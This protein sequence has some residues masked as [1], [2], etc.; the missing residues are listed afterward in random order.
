MLT[1]F[2]DGVQPFL[3]LEPAVELDEELEILVHRADQLL[4]MGCET[5]RKVTYFVFV[6]GESSQCLEFSRIVPSLQG[7]MDTLH[8]AKFWGPVRDAVLGARQFPLQPDLSE[9]SMAYLLL[10]YPCFML[11]CTTARSYEGVDSSSLLEVGLQL[12]VSDEF[13]EFVDARHLQPMARAIRRPCESLKER[14][15]LVF[16]WGSE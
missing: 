12:Q 4:S 13:G 10:P 8:S 2:H 15:S 14:K 7:G 16:F 1:I 9:P 3:A 6:G 5:P 11:L